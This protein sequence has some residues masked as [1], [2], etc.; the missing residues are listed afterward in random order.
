MQAL[1]NCAGLVLRRHTVVA[2][3][4]GADGTR[5]ELMLWNLAYVAGVQPL[6]QQP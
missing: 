6:T 5:G 3:R 2:I 1:D 4:A